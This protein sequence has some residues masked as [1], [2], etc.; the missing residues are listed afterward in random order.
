[1]KLCFFCFYFIVI[2][3]QLTFSVFSIIT[4]INTPI[5]SYVYDC[6]KK[7]H[8]KFLTI[9]AFIVQNIYI[10]FS[11]SII[12]IHKMRSEYYHQSFNKIE[13]HDIKNSENN[14][15]LHLRCAQSAQNNNSVEMK[16]QLQNTNNNN[17]QENENNQENK[18]HTIKDNNINK[19]YN[20]DVLYQRYAQG[21]EDNG[22]DNDYV[23]DNK[24]NRALLSSSSSSPPR[25]ELDVSEFEK[26][27]IDYEQTS[28]PL[29]YFNYSLIIFL[30]IY[31]IIAVTNWNTSLN[32]G[33]LNFTVDT[34]ILNKSKNVM[35]Q[36]ND[37]YRRDKS[38][39]FPRYIKNTCSE[40]HQRIGTLYYT[41]Y[42]WIIFQ[43]CVLAFGT[44]V[45]LLAISKHFKIVHKI[46]KCKNFL[47]RSKSNTYVSF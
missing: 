43:K 32:G 11:C 10:Y 27:E 5:K 12:F 33:D 39:E 29:R 28:K 25:V 13:T 8:L 16:N 44:I 4:V 31:S 23:Y 42:R 36:C 3:L 20:E 46:A 19:D 45:A 18:I 17:Q 38:C 41:Y 9:I 6:E 2:V 1:M 40:N 35:M 24:N 30:Y 14:D 34:G 47:F 21:V 15:L 26:I 22:D 37:F 7:Y